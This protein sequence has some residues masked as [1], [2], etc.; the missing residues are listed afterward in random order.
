[1]LTPFFFADRL[2]E[3]VLPSL[4]FWACAI[5][6]LESKNKASVIVDREKKML[7]CERLVSLRAG[8][9]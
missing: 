7:G 8:F 1:L 9:A 6:G 5:S 2:A 3:A 4:V